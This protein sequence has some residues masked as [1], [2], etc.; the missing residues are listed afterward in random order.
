[1][2]NLI[3]IHI[4]HS[5]NENPEWAQQC[6]DSLNDQPVNIFELDGIPGDIRQARYNG[7]QQGN[8]PYVS[9]VDPDDFVYPDTYNICLQEL[10]AD[11][12]ICGVYT[13][14]NVEKSDN[15]SLM[16]PYRPWS[17]E[18]HSTN[19]CEVHQVTVMKRE[20]V[21]ECYEQCFT[22]IP[23]HLY[24]QAYLYLYL[25]SK[26]PWKAINHIGYHWRDHEVG[27][28]NIRFHEFPAGLIKLQQ[29][30]RQRVLSE[31]FIRL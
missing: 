4:L 20:L 1:M 27:N 9:F 30:I 17:L 19:I 10:T 7:F 18:L 25:A 6:V 12:N 3:D 29:Q 26:Q 13:T 31:R 11:P 16:H 24:N 21:L 23:P 28:H 5:P 14:S 15:V 8:A 22:D 2:N